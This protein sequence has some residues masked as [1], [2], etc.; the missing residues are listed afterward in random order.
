MFARNAGRDPIEISTPS[1]SVIPEFH[2]ENG[3]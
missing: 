2:V 1:K 3:F